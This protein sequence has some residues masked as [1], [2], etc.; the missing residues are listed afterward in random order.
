VV[1]PDLAGY[2]KDEGFVADRGNTGFISTM[3]NIG[4]QKKTCEGFSYKL[5]SYEDHIRRVL[6]TFDDT[7]SKEL[8]YAAMAL[9]RAA[10]WSQGSVMRA[11]WLAC[12]FHD[13]GKLSVGWQ[14]WARAY[15]KEIGA[16]VKQDFSAGH[17][18]FDRKNPVHDKAEKAV[19]QKHPKP[20]HAG[21]SALA[22]A[23]MISKAFNLPAEAG[24]VKAI[25]TAI[26]RHHTPFA[27]ECK[28][29]LLEQQ[30]ETHIYATFDFAPKEVRQRVNLELLR[31]E[32]RTIDNSFPNLLIT[33][34]DNFGWL[35]YALLARALRRSDQEGTARGTR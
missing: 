15:Q 13:V 5:E 3:P 12:L 33:P 27:S 7:F 17:T 28:A 18:E 26:T 24:L 14:G 19:R 20:N 11:V 16:S 21:E 30:A 29:F 9:E 31:N 4:E 25:L 32:S 22:T 1:N 34:D 2:L 35:A 23:K 6:S 10:G 8:L